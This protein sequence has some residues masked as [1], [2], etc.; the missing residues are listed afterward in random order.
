MANGARDVLNASTR[1]ADGVMVIVGYFGF[2][3]SG[4]PGEIYPPQKTGIHEIVEH[5][6]SGLQRKLGKLGQGFAVNFFR[7]GVRMPTGSLQ[8]A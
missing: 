7:G 8:H 2:K 3:A 1:N 5:H 6:V 4:M